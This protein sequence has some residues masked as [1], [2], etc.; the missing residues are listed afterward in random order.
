MKKIYSMIALMTLVVSAN[1]QNKAFRTV[2]PRNISITA[3]NP[4]IQ[5]GVLTSTTTALQPASFLSTSACTVTTY[6]AGADGYV[7]GTNAYGDK[8]KSQKYDLT[9]YGLTTPASVNGVVMIIPYVTGTGSVTAK[10]YTD[11]AGLPGSLLGTSLPIGLS[12]VNTATYTT[13]MFGSAVNLTGP[14]FH[15]ALDFSATNSA[16]GDTVL[17]AQTDDGCADNAVNASSEQLSDNSWQSFTTASPAGWGFTSTDLAIFPVVTADIVSVRNLVNNSA[18]ISVFPN[19]ANNVVTVDFTS[20]VTAA[21][22]QIFDVTGKMVI[23]S[24]LEN[25]VN[26]KNSTKVDISSL[27]SGVYM[28]SVKTSNGNAFKKFVVTK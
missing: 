3:I 13:F 18:S 23:S 25:V 14:V 9:T 15:V 22:V 5:N 27:V 26:G 24:E 17:V 12:S 28:L 4:S 21:N 8:A 7:A 10:V 2:Q 1:A 6:G 16:G 19:P 20:N 11:N